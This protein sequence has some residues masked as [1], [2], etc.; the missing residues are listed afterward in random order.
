MKTTVEISNGLLLEAKRVAARE[1]TTVRALVEEGLR[2]ALQERR[3]K[4]GFRLRK[5][6]F[7]GDG[8]QPDVAAGSWER[9]RELLYHGRGA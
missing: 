5:A 7:R 9:I 4:D 6:S 8:L 1:R 3:R 2:R